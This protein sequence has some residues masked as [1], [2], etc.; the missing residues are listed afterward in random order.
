MMRHLVLLLATLIACGSSHEAS[1]AGDIVLASHGA[2][3]S[4]L[5]DTLKDAQ[6]AIDHGHPWRATQLLSPLLRNPRTRTPLAILT[7]ARA[8]AG[9][10][11]WAEVDR[12]LA[13]EPW[14][15]AQF[16]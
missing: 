3:A 1:A 12:L 8:A 5:S 7:A 11:G 10:G 2:P 4:Q 14:I 6:D 13:K 16:D 9:W 15:D